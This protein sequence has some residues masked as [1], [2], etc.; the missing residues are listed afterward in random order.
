MISIITIANDK[1]LLKE[2]LLRSLKNQTVDYELIVIDNAD[3]K[4]FNHVTKALNYGASLTKGDCL[5]FVHQDVALWG[6]NFLE[7]FEKMLMEIQDI[8]IGGVAG[9]TN[10]G[11]S[12]LFLKNDGALSGR[13]FL[14]PVKVK[15]L[16]EMLLAVPRYVFDRIPFDEN[17]PGW[18]CYGSD[19]CLEVE[20]FNLS[21]YVLP[22]F[23]HHYSAGLRPKGLTYSLNYL[24]DKW[25]SM[26]HGPWCISEVKTVKKPLQYAFMRRLLDDIIDPIISKK[27]LLFYFPLYHPEHSQLP[28]K[29]SVEKFDVNDSH[30]YPIT[31][32]VASPNEFSEI[33]KEKY[34]VG[35]VIPTMQ[36]I[37]LDNA[38]K[39]IRPFAKR[40]IVR[41]SHNNLLRLYFARLFS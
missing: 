26:Y 1:K 35:Y 5:M 27:T 33:V 18:H 16:D 4:Q 41:K 38:V 20:K 25:G 7:R 31:V 8:G 17:L 39:V 28:L 3:N 6:N 37:N 29:F 40:V 36:D 30:E 2:Y 11:R 22:F 19:Y 32:V 23:V 15:R 9:V 14:R 10:G 24:K 12:Y 21:A 34:N 13:P